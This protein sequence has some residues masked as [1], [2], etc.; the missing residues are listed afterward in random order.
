[1]CLSFYI[2]AARAE[3]LPGSVHSC[4]ISHTS[5]PDARMYLTAAPQLSQLNDNLCSSVTVPES[6]LTTDDNILWHNHVAR[7]MQK[8]SNHGHDCIDNRLN[9]NLNTDLPTCFDQNA[10]LISTKQGTTSPQGSSLSSSKSPIELFQPNE[11]LPPAYRLQQEYDRQNSGQSSKRP[12]SRL[13]SCP[14]KRE[15]SGQSKVEES[16]FPKS[17][18]VKLAKL[19][20]FDNQNFGEGSD[21]QDL[22]SD[23]KKLAALKQFDN[24]FNPSPNLPFRL[25]N[26]PCQDTTVSHQDTE[27]ADT[28]L[29]CDPNKLA[30]LKNFDQRNIPTVESHALQE[31]GDLDL[32]AT[33]TSDPHKLDYLS[34]FDQANLDRNEHSPAHSQPVSEALLNNV[35]YLQNEALKDCH[36]SHLQH[37]QPLQSKLSAVE[38]TSEA[39]S[40]AVSLHDK[41]NVC[42]D[43]TPVPAAHNSASNDTSCADP[44]LLL[45]RRNFFEE[46]EAQINDCDDDSNGVEDDYDNDADENDE[47]SESDGTNTQESGNE[48]ETVP[49]V[50]ES[51]HLYQTEERLNGLHIASTCE[52]TMEKRLE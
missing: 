19:D 26:M 24:Q 37:N 52:I 1:M 6:H 50:N 12:I 28:N 46:Y 40:V 23:P 16:E 35:I 13:S 38:N 29:A 21:P 51:C 45:R 47:E 5:S 18:P 27:S 4:H 9:I 41:S 25:V 31:T 8:S 22:R 33:L 14:P 30:Y 43:T 2:G 34:N 32:Q 15:C 20:H 17:D 10:F 36:A 44:T 39:H 7:Q 48:L 3:S 42:V 49:S 11:D